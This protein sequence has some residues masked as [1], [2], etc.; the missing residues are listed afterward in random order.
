VTISQNYF[1][2]NLYHMNYSVLD[3]HTLFQDLT[4]EIN[5][6]Q[7]TIVFDAYIWIDDKIGNSILQACLDA[8]ERG[9]KIFIRKDLSASIFE[10]TPGRSPMFFDDSLFNKR[11]VD[12]FDKKYGFL[13]PQTLNNLAYYIYGR[14]PRPVLKKNELIKKIENHKNIYL[15]DVPLLNHG[16]LILIDDLAYVGGQCISC[17]YQEWV[18]YNIKIEDDTVVKNIWNQIL[19][20]TENLELTDTHFVDN[21]F[22]AKGSSS[23]KS[24][25]HF[26]KDFI[27]TSSEELIIEMAYL[28]KWYVPTLKK[29]IKRGVK[30]KILVS[31]NPDTNHHTNMWVLSDLLRLKA[32]NFEIFFTNEKMIHTKGLA[33]K[34]KITIGATNFHGA[35]GYFFGLNEQNIHSTN[36]E[37][38]DTVFSKFKNDL[39]NAKRVTSES[40]L[41]KWNKAN[42]LTEIFFVYLSSYITFFN[43]KKISGWRNEAVQTLKTNLSI[44]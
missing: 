5:K 32:E 21:R 42:A 3:R 18:D 39:S 26:L 2:N 6:S 4:K 15:Q 44:N 36:K 22:P 27:D 30:L 10:H 8:A 37:L 13:T 14:K 24:I 11:Q 1:K 33:T 35:C 28:G 12:F 31:K 19:G 41:P 38:V 43:K 17:D 9:V 40:E 7:K 16:K 20:E 25:H 29:A 23:K 34:D